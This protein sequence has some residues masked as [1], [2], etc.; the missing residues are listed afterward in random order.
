MDPR[1][2][3]RPGVARRSLGRSR[4]VPV[5]RELAQELFGVVGVIDGNATLRRA[6]AD[7][8]REG[9]DK[10]ALAERLFA[11]QGERRDARRPQGCR[12][13]AL[14][15]GARPVRHPRGLRHRD[16]HRLGRDGRPGGS[17]RGR[18]VPL[19]AHRRGQRAA[20]GSAGRRDGPAGQARGPRRLAA[21]RQGRG[22]DPRA[23]TPGSDRPSRSSLRPHCEQLP[24]DGVGPTGAA[25]GD[26][27]VGGATHRRTTA[28]VWLRDFRRSTVAGCTSTPSSTLGSS[29][30]SR[31]R[32]A[33][34]SSTERS[35]ASSTAHAGPWAPSVPTRHTPALLN[36]TDSLSAGRN[37]GEDLT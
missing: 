26:S 10:A 27:H 33:T 29:A 35:C 4:P 12:R 17:R 24:R 1:V 14:E 25:D 19:R 8:S 22:R 21:F 2:Q 31:S 3:R 18:A 16:D 6:L 23:G 11:G 36:T 34:R 20:Q 15:H 28:S 30:A 32:S 5:V 7:P 37:R 9:A 13:A